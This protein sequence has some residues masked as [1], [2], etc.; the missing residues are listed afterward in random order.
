MWIKDSMYK[1]KPNEITSLMFINE[2]E[3]KAPSINEVEDL[4]GMKY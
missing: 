4:I 3:A 2:F 1:P